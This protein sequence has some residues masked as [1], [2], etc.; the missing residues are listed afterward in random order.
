MKKDESGM[1]SWKMM[2]IVIV[3][4][5]IV[6]LIGWFTI[7]GGGEVQKK[8]WFFDLNTGQLFAGNVNDVPPI[9]APSGD[10]KNGPP[11][12]PAGVLACVIKI[13]GCNERKIVFIETFSPQIQ[14]LAL[15]KRRENNLAISPEEE[16]KIRS[17]TFVAVPPENPGDPVRWVVMSSSEGNKIIMGMD[18][19]AGGRQYSIDLP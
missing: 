19:I 10:Y 6:G 2:A 18:G 15:N 9:V 5:I 14:E 12:T 17:G 4:L 1:F 11:G 3:A 8:I 13:E 16:V 7:D